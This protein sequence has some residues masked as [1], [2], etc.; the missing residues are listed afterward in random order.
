MPVLHHEACPMRDDRLGNSPKVVYIRAEDH[1]RADKEGLKDI[2]S[3]VRRKAAADKG[4]RALTIDVHQVA[5]RVHEDNV[6]FHRPRTL[7]RRI[8]FHDV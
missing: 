3:S 7:V 6:A 5:N 1:G 4:D 8:A 2:L